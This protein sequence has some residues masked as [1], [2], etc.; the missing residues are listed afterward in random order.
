MSFFAVEYV[1]SP[2]ADADDVRP[3]HRA[4]L[5]QLAE[6][7]DLVASGPF[8]GPKT[9]GALLIMRADHRDR[10]ADLLDRDPFVTS[11]VVATRTITEWDP[12]IGV[13]AG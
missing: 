7:G 1:Y 6:S 9:P 2:A 11:G 3:A 12:V 5:R 13:F 4:Y 10:V 8:V